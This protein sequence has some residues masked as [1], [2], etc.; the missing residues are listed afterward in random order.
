MSNNLQLTQQTTAPA[1]TGGAMIDTQIARE[2]QEVQAMMIVA[3]KFPR[4][5]KE[6]LDR[7]LNAC[8]REGLAGAAVYQYGR[9]GADVTGPSIRLAEAI[10]QNWGNLQ[11][12]IR[13][14]E[15]RDGESTVEAFCWDM[16]SNVRQVKTFQ[17]AHTRYSKSKGNTR[18]TDP[19]DIYEMTA[20]QGARR[21]RACILGVIPGDVVEAAVKACEQ[22]LNV[23]AKVTPETIKKTI[24]AFGKYGVSKAQIEAR[25]Q[26]RIETMTP[27][28]LVNLRKIYNSLDNGASEAK[29]WFD[30]VAGGDGKV[31][32]GQS[33]LA[34]VEVPKTPAELD[35]LPFD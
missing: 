16:E 6:A 35:S 34:A 17:V 12:G 28:Q 19:R 20:N 25:I 29:D 23:T 33:P 11:F 9:G 18:L 5:E 8:Q 14:L 7:I 22:T 13:E 32:K 1:R 26:R 3:K 30:A 27:A 24:E 4:N 21:L 15:Q 2:A 10:A 31:G